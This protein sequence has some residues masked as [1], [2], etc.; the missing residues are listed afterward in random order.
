VYNLL[1]AVL[2]LGLSFFT[3]PIYI[4]LI[5]ESRYGVLA[6]AWLLLG[7]FGLFDMGLGRAT[8]QRI[9]SLG[10]ASP[11]Q[12]ASI[13]WTALTMN[14]SVGVVGGLVIWPVAVFFFGHVFSVDAA[15]RPELAAAIPWL[16]LAL[17][18]ATLSGVLTGALEGRLQFLELNI[19][20]AFSSVLIQLMPLAVA[21]LH[22]PDLAWLLPAVIL[23]RLV[24]LSVLFSRCR[25]HVFQG[26]ARTISRTLAKGLL[27]FGGWVT[28]SS[29]VGPM[30]VMLDRFVIGA[31]L[32]AKAVTYYTVPFQL[33]E[34]STV[35]PGALASALFPRLAAAGI[36]DARQLAATAIRSLAV[37]MTPLMLI[38]VLLVE[39]FLRWWLNPE[40]ALRAGLTAQILLLGFWINAFARVPY[41]QL[42]AAGKPSVVAKC[43]LGELIPYLLLLYVSLHFWGLP[44][45]AM[46]FGLRTL[47][48]CALLLW[49]ADT[50]GGGIAVLKT[51]VLLLLA[52]SGV[53]ACL[54]TGSAMWWLAAFSLLLLSL[55]WSWRNA[56]PEVRNLALRIVSKLTID[57]RE[58]FL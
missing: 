41:A 44:G 46:V 34:R 53:A 51:P 56:P 38:G 20:S 11:T 10:D 52:G 4:R 49:L 39:P 25:V 3:I 22:G 37:V 1:G 47:V 9:A 17:P 30:M 14:I 19:I 57:K 50:L 54:S 13:F 42:Q 6:V 15:L 21:W 28:V 2:P 32:G 12:R 27:Q 58:K 24:T 36:T 45:A 33:A 5:G 40:F 8:A 31:A 43:H 23:A 55:V 48:D 26:H 16:I 35:L 7:Y 29:L 18:L